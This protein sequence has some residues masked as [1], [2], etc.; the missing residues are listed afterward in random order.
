MTNRCSCEC[1]S[2]TLINY[3]DESLQQCA[4]PQISDTIDSCRTSLTPTLRLVYWF[5]EV[6]I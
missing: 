2:F 6:V 3:D 5:L 4:R 1:D